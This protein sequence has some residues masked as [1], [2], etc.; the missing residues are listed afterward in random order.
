MGFLLCPG[1]LGKIRHQMIGFRYFRLTPSKHACHL[2]D[3]CAERERD[4]APM[5]VDGK[6][7]AL[8]LLEMEV[9]GLQALPHLVDIWEPKHFNEWVQQVLPKY[10]MLIARW[11]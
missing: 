3:F 1:E 2:V 7:Q 6:S 5:E 9:G 8:A 11:S 4:A 10:S